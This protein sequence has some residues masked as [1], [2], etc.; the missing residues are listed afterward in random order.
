MVISAIYV[1]LLVVNLAEP[2]AL[3]LN[4]FNFEVVV[5]K[6]NA[7]VFPEIIVVP[8]KIPPKTATP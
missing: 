5:P 2:L 4:E 1:V 8:V 6:K 3:I 7:L